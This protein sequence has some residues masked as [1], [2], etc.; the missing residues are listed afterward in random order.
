MTTNTSRILRS[1]CL[2]ALAGHHTVLWYTLG[3]PQLITTAQGLVL[4]PTN[5]ILISPASYWEMAIKVSLG[6]LALHRPYEEF[7]DAC[8]NKYGF[9]ILAIE[10]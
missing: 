8:L 7:L 3:D 6:K 5:E 4:D 9:K 2:E 1:T 10:P